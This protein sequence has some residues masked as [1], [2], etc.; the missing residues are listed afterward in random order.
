[1]RRAEVRSGKAFIS[2][3]GGR[4]PRGSGEKAATRPARPVLAFRGILAGRCVA[5]GC[6]PE[7]ATMAAMAKLDLLDSV[8]ALRQQGRSPK[9]IARAL[10]VP[11]AVVAPL[12]RLVA[13]EHSET[14]GGSAREG[15]ARAADLVGCW[16]NRDWANGLTVRGQP[17][18][19]GLPAGA[20]NGCDGLA[21]VVVA[22]EAPGSKL[23]ACTYLVDVFCLGVKDAFGPR[24]FPRRRLSEFLGQVYGSYADPPVAAPLDLARHVVF[25]A[26]THAR[27]LGFEPHADF[28]PAAGHLGPWEPPE[29]S[30]IEFGRDGKPLYVQGPY[31][32]YRQILRTLEQS[33]GADG[34]DYLVIAA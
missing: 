24:A 21:T 34:F 3:A 29:S 6:A 33:V 10:A 7:G 12:V 16:I 23:A 11:P 27:G 18:W 25:G 5:H 9:E 2:V 4:R 22:R 15:S 14:G 20:S 8:R 31:D 13:A 28:G 30:S 17:D 1:M 32:D 19:P 26:I